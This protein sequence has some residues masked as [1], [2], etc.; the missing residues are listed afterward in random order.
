MKSIKFHKSQLKRIYELIQKEGKFKLDI[1]SPLIITRVPIVNDDNKIIAFGMLKIIP[2]AIIVLDKDLSMTEKTEAV[3][4]LAK[5]GELSARAHGL[6]EID[7]FITDDKSFTNFL[8]KRLGFLDSN[9]TVLVK[10][11]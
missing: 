9:S 11:L 4:L 3:E 2:E 10:R 5:I 6:D 7:A 1:T 8:M